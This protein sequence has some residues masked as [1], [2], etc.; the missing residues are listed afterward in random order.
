[1]INVILWFLGVIERKNT[2]VYLFADCLGQSDLSFCNIILNRIW[3]RLNEIICAERLERESRLITSF[4][5]II[6]IFTV[7][8]PILR[9]TRVLFIFWCVVE[10][11]LCIFYTRTIF[12]RKRK[13]RRKWLL[14]PKP[15]LP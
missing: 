15:L 9:W 5:I 12:K 11:V 10:A 6:I 7:R 8:V 1:M 14:T 3:I 4:I 2:S 13:R